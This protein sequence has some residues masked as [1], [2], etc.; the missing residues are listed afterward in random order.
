MRPDE[1]SK[2]EKAL[3]LIFK[4]LAELGELSAGIQKSAIDLESTL[5]GTSEKTDAPKVGSI[6]PCGGSIGEM[7]GKI[8]FLISEFQISGDSLV[9]IR[10]EV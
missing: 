10:K 1:G 2:R 9:R 3:E 4:G 6:P 7:I 8:R 5:V